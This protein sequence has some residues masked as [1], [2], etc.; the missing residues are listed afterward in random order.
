MK[1]QSLIVQFLLFFVLGLALFASI[2]GIFRFHS[3]ILREDVAEANRKLIGSYISSIAISMASNCKECNSTTFS[4]KLE[5]VTANYVMVLSLSSKGLQIFSEP[6]GGNTSVSIH[7]LNES[8]SLNR[9]ASSTLPI[10]LKF[11][12]TSHKAELNLTSNQ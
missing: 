8:F 2:G 1:G 9:N 5:N 4:L 12:N 6:A 7:N 10:T 11:N 3:D